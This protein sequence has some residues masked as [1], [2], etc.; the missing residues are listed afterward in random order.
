MPSP[1]H[2]P[3]GTTINHQPGDST[4]PYVGVVSGSGGTT[5]TITYVI[6][7]ESVV[8]VY[9]WTDLGAGVSVWVRDSLWRRI[10]YDDGTYRVYQGALLI[11]SGTY[12]TG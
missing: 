10:Y 8:R 4:K 11:E 12:T 2:H 7:G 9:T 3:A 6:E 5:L 1:V